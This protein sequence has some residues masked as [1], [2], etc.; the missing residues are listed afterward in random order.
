MR[1]AEKALHFAALLPEIARHAQRNPDAPDD[2]YMDY[3]RVR[4]EWTDLAVRE[5][6]VIRDVITIAR[7]PNAY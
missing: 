2:F 5:R 3:A 4:C 1:Q 7:H 6:N